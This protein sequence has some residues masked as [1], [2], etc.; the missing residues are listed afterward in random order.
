MLSLQ[1][2]KPGRWCP[3]CPPYP[4]A[5]LGP[6]AFLGSHQ[7]TLP[8]HA[9]AVFACGRGVLAGEATTVPSQGPSQMELPHEK[10]LG[11]RWC[12]WFGVSVFV[13]L[14]LGLPLRSLGWLIS[15]SRSVSATCLISPGS[16]SSTKV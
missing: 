6:S 4:T 1:V 11:I 14:G 7:G 3:P 16:G 2:S 8:I 15:H 10:Q 13:A 12:L 9:S 5:L